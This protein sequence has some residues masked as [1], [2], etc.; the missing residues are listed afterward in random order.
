MWVK[1]FVHSHQY[2]QNLNLL[3]TCKTSR[4]LACSHP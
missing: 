1:I 2:L 4:N 3:C